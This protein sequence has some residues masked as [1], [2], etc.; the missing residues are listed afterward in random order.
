MEIRKK[1]QFKRF[2]FFSFII[3]STTAMII[4][5]TPERI[6]KLKTSLNAITPIIIAV[7]G[8]KGESRAVIVEPI[9]LIARI[10]VRLEIIV[11]IIAIR[12]IL[13]PAVR[14][15]IGVRLL[16]KRLRQRQTIIEITST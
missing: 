7:T 11:V 2:Y 15:G 6:W 16:L 5:I 14:E 4:M 9:D 3:I 1:N 12:L 13:I 10:R 8:S